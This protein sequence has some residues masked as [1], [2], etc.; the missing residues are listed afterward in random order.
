MTRRRRLT[1]EPGLRGALINQDSS[2][3]PEGPKRKGAEY[4]SRLDFTVEK[5]IRGQ[6]SLQI[7]VSNGFSSSNMILVLS[8]G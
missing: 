6:P 1:G 7:F 4:V 2:E 5:I 3:I 8:L